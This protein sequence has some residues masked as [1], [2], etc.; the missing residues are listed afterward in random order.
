MSSARYLGQASRERLVAAERRLASLRLAAL[1]MVGAM[2]PFY[3]RGL[4]QPGIAYGVLS[5]GVVYSLWIFHFDPVWRRLGQRAL[6]ALA[7]ADAAFVMVFI[8]AT[9]GVASP[10]YIL[11]FLTVPALASGLA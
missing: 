10:F 2:L 7:L 8:Y 1:G 4:L 5:T 9:G 6:Y 11:L 3:D